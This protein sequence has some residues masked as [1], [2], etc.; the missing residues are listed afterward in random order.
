[1]VLYAYVCVCAFS[2]R[3]E[4]P[5]R[6]LG[7]KP[8]LFKG[9]GGVRHSVAAAR[10][11]RARVMCGWPSKTG[12]TGVAAI[13]GPGKSA[14]RWRLNLFRIQIPT[15]FKLISNRFKFWLSQKEPS[16]AQIF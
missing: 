6:I 11:Q 15:D 16:Q 13:C 9:G 1:M 4:S 2:L 14:G 10:N 8:L 5:D 3:R 7:D 12:N